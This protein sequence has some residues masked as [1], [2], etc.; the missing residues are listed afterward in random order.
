VEEV[1]QHTSRK[2]HMEAMAPYMMGQKTWPK[3]V[4]DES[5]LGIHP[6]F[7]LTRAQL[8]ALTQPLAYKGICN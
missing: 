2:W 5:N 4:Y 8:A 1:G 7:N 6:K 3:E